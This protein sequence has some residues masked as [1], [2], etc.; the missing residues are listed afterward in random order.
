MGI[1]LVGISR[2]SVVD[3]F[4]LSYPYIYFSVQYEEQV[5][6][7]VMSCVLVSFSGVGIPLVDLY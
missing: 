2:L 6:D 3:E 4:A 5:Y 1:S 7:A